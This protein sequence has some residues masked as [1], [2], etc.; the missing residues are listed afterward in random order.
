MWSSVCN[1]PHRLD[2]TESDVLASEEYDTHECY[3]PNN[4]EPGFVADPDFGRVDVE[5]PFDSDFN[6]GVY[7]DQD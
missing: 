1:W 6:V 3:P 5:A 4:A 7:I 2:V